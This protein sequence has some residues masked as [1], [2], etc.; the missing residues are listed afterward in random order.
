MRDVRDRAAQRRSRWRGV[1]ITGM[2]SAN[3]AALLLIRHPALT[4]AEVADVLRRRWPDVTLSDGTVPPTWEMTVEDAVELACER[5]G[6][7]PLRVVVLPQRASLTD[8][9]HGVGVLAA[10]DLEPMPVLL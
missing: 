9:R 4:R 7:E 8:G 2:T 6:V 3:G 10:A 1:A 5:R